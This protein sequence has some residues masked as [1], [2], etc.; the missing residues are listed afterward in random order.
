MKTESPAGSFERLVAIMARL[1]SAEGCPWD[2]EQTHQTLRP[3]VIE[4][5]YEVVQALDDG[6]MPAL[7]EELGD[8]L[9]QVV[10]H[11]QIASESGAFGVA[12]VCGTISDKLIRRHPHVFADVTV[13]GPAGVVANWEQIKAVEKGKKAP[14]ILDEIPAHL[15]ALMRAFKL[16][17]RAARVG[18]DWPDYRG[19]LEKVDEEMSEF[20]QALQDAG[21]PQGR[22]ERAGADDK[23]EEE[24]G[25]LLF[26]LVN[27]AR[28]LGI[29]PE[30]ALN[31]TNHKFTRRF[32][33][34]EQ[35][36]QAEGRKL[37]DMSLPEMDRYWNAAKE[38]E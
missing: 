17:Q 37:E 35:G 20:R 5:A 31:R 15:P 12:D 30:V 23:V 18:F 10:F 13:E 8:V 19:A 28:F 4:E 24:F 38:E 7:R 11:A 34:V 36:A 16:Q 9:L 14:S 2:R 26:A 22:I 27:T 29:D 33:R 25:D 21:A 32:A 6:D 3:Y 1:R